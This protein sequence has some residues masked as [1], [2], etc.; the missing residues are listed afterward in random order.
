MKK[1][2]KLARGKRDFSLHAEVW[3]YTDPFS[4]DGRNKK[5]KKTGAV[6]MKVNNM[7][8]YVKKNK[9][10]CFRWLGFV[11]FTFQR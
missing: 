1:K 11:L 2:K 5:K 6:G 9:Q 10:C 3:N 8:D 4:I 7:H